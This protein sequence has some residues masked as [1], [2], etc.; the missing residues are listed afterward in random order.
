MSEHETDPLAELEEGIEVETP[1][2]ID[3]DDEMP[4]DGNRATR[5]AATQAANR[6]RKARKGIDRVVKYVRDH[7]EDYLK[8]SLPQAYK[9]I[10]LQDEYYHDL[11]QAFSILSRYERLG[12][13]ANAHQV[14]DDLIKLHGHL[15]RL[16]GVVGYFSGTA[17]QAESAHKITRAGAY[18]TAKKAREI[19]RQSVTDADADNI[20]KNVTGN[21]EDDARR[22]GTVALVIK[23]AYFAMSRFAET[24][25]RIAQRINRQET[26][27]A[28]AR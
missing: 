18:L 21:T 15:I 12:F 23:N 22:V 1:D 11:N 4:L 8:V 13:E 5:E 10:L 27:D 7:E 16:A 2:Q 6:V 25:E 3:Q 14:N 19:L 26:R 24:L 20:S 28:R 17:I 9:D